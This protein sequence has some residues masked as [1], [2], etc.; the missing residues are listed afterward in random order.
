[1][2]DSVLSD[3]TLGDWIEDQCTQ[4]DFVASWETLLSIY[5]QMGFTDSITD[6]QRIEEFKYVIHETNRFLSRIRGALRKAT[7]MEA[8]VEVLRRAYGSN[9]SQAPWERRSL[10]FMRLKQDWVVARV[11]ELEQTIRTMM[12]GDTDGW[13]D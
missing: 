13:T 6:A 10:V 9:D 5:D 3:E 12:M 1:M 8:A 11:N 4:R 2:F 7:D